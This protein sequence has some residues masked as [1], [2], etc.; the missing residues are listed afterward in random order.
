MKSFNEFE[1]TEEAIDIQEQRLILINQSLEENKRKIGK[2]LFGFITDPKRRQMA[3]QQ[4]D[5]QAMQL[6]NGHNQ[7]MMMQNQQL[8]Q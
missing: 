3:I 1:S 4:G 6:M 5:M 8:V 2:E 7:N